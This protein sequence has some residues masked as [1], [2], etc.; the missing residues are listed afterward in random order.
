MPAGS[1]HKALS[2]RTQRPK[3]LA[4]RTRSIP[5][6]MR[7]TR[8]W[9]LWRWEWNEKAGRWAK[10]PRQVN[11][12]LASST[13]TGTWFDF[14]S[15][16]RVYQQSL[17]RPVGEWFSGI[18]FELGDGWAGVDLDG[19][20]DPET[21]KLHPA[22]TGIVARL[23]S[24][25]EV[26]PTGTGVKIL[27]QGSL[28]AG[29]RRREDRFGPDTGI[30]TYDSRR[31]F[32]VTGVRVAVAERTKE[33]TE[34]WSEHVATSDGRPRAGHDRS[35]SS[36][37]SAQRSRLSR[38]GV[39]EH[40]GCRG[41]FADAEVLER[42]RRAA[43]GTTF[44]RLYGGQWQGDY[45]SQ[46]EADLALVRML[47]FW[48]GG[49]REQIDRLFRKSKL[50]RLKWDR[51]VGGGITYGERTIAF[52]L[53][54]G[55]PTYSGNNQSR[56][57]EA[58]A[59][60]KVIRARAESTRW[61]GKAGATDKAVFDRLA[62]LATA[63]GS[64]EFGASVRWI[65][66]QVNTKA[67]TASRSTRRL[68]AR[69]FLV[70]LARGVG[71]SATRWRLS[72]PPHASR[73]VLWGDSQGLHTIGGYRGDCPHCGHLRQGDRGRAEHDGGRSGVRSH[74]RKHDVWRWG[75]QG[76]ATPRVCDLLCEHPRSTAALA[77]RLG[78]TISGVSKHLRRLR[79]HRL[80]VHV[81]RGFWTRGTACLDAIAEELGVAGAGA[82]DR[83]RH[84]QERVEY[85]T[86]LRRR[87]LRLVPSGSSGRAPVVQQA[88]C[89]TPRRRRPSSRRASEKVAVSPRSGGHCRGLRGVGGAYRI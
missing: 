51:S 16:V 36:E 10:V 29:R 88:A 53:Q 71:E 65:A 74:D 57:S 1:K 15:V 83:A 81:R 80:A 27:V 73:D 46:S 84:I 66:D 76:K 72:A 68:I 54:S 78:L 44:S 33:L 31:Y 3:A 5:R 49:D 41:K 64:T 21:G 56:K 2:D 67:D 9:H 17:R 6:S 18:G 50:Y 39:A 47:Y 89:A 61:S 8:R 28:P 25:S 4:V 12:Q 55:G 63:K 70:R 69:G 75:G 60:I 24:Y 40:A 30:E 59:E 23:S 86:R 32:A 62:D 34:I 11:G 13:D 22:A 26:S 58:R 14:K 85:R 87:N 52:V 82:R 77:D 45:P 48:T 20:L 43:K 37:P 42:A 79:E 7:C 35:S 19:V 38:G